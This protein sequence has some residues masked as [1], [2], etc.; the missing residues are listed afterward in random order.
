M[1]V[2]NKWLF[3]GAL[4]LCSRSIGAAREERT[5]ARCG[6]RNGSYERKLTTRVGTLELEVPRDRKGTFQTELSDRYQRSE[7][8]PVLALMQMV[9]QGVSMRRVKKITSE[10]CGWRFSKSTVSSL[11]ED[12]DGQVEAWATRPLEVCPFL[13]CD[14]LQVKV[15][16][17]GAVRSTTVLL[18]VGVTAGEQRE[19]L[20]LKVA[21]GETGPAWKGLLRSLKERGLTD[22]EV[23]TSDANEG[24]RPAIDESFAGAIWQRCHRILCTESIRCVAH[25][26]RNV[27]DQMSARMKAEM[28]EALDTILGPASPGK[29]HTGFEEATAVLAFS[30]KYRRRLRTTNMI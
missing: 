18:A 9:V 25:F 11:T 10:L 22:V 8:A 23:A 4:L 30:A 15:R 21:F 17:H 24:L 28:H 27:I 12:L 5:S 16:R 14:A 19:I 26:R 20:G 6:Y 2:R 3:P 13:I 29:A 7:K 1:H